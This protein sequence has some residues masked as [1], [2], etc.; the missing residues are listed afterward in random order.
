MPFMCY[1]IQRV[2]DTILHFSVIKRLV[3]EEL[4]VTLDISVLGY[5]NLVVTI[6]RR[7]GVKN[8]I[9]LVQSPL[10]ILQ[11]ESYQITVQLPIHTGIQFLT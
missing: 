8:V 6:K 4:G 10:V 5:Q 7:R 9:V 11:A 2:K 3:G 1:K